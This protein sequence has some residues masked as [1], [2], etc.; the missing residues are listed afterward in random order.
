[1]ESNYELLLD[2]DKSL[3]TLFG[4]VVKSQIKEA[5]EYRKAKDYISLTKNSNRKRFFRKS[6]DKKVPRLIILFQILNK[7]TGVFFEIRQ[8][9]ES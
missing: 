8:N 1:M 7:I 4:F 3:V 2:R 6:I 9:S 5:P